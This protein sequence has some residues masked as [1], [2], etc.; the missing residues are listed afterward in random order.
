MEL[1]VW[2]RGKSA[3]FICIDSSRA[4]WWYKYFWPFFNIIT[5]NGVQIPTLMTTQETHCLKQ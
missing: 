1:G 5:I 4:R 2:E 3:L